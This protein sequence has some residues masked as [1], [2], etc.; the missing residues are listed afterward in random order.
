MS[1]TF[2]EGERVEIAVKGALYWQT[3]VYIGRAHRLTGEPYKGWYVVQI[4][5]DLFSIPSKRIRKHGGGT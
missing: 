3:A 5:Q 1:K 4:W 2:S